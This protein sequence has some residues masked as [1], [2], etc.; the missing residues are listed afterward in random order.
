[1]RYLLTLIVVVVFLFSMNLHGKNKNPKS[2]V[3]FSKNEVLVDWIFYS[4][5]KIMLDEKNTKFYTSRISY[6]EI[7][8]SYVGINVGFDGGVWTDNTS[9]AVP[10]FFGLNFDIFIQPLKVFNLYV[11]LNA[12]KKQHQQHGGPTLNDHYLNMGIGFNF[13]NFK[14]KIEGRKNLRENDNIGVSALLGYR[15]F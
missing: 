1:M 4:G 9:S 7:F 10:Y 11:G 13:G 8:F 14:L 3:D 5:V 2:E 6:Q 15:F 12:G